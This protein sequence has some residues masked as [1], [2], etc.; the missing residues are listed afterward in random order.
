VDQAG[1]WIE[2]T[3]GPAAI[4]LPGEPA[5]L[6]PAGILWHVYDT[7]A[8]A[9]SA[10]L[11]DA[12]NETWIGWNLNSQRLSH[13]LT[14]GGGIPDFEY[15]IAGNPVGV[16][17][18]SAENA[19]LGVASVQ[20]TS[21]VTLYGFNKIGGA[22]PIWTLP[23][24]DGYNTVQFTS[25]DVAADGSIVVV[26]ASNGGN[27]DSRILLIDGATGLE[28]RHLQRPVNVIG[29]ELCDDGSRMILSENAVARVFD[30]ATLGELFNFSVSGGGGYHRI[31]RNGKVV[32]AGGFD[33][34]AYRDTGSGWVSAYSFSEASNW[35]GY[36]VAVSG[37]GKTLFDV[38]HNYNGYLKLTYRV[39][40]L[41]SGTELAKI[42]TQGAGTFQ[43][44]VARAQIS[45]DGSVMASA[46]WGSQDN[47]HPEVQVFDR[48]L[49]VIGSIDTPGSPFD[50]DLSRDGRYVAVGCKHVHA[51]TYGNGGDAYAFL[52]AT[53]YPKGDMNCD[54]VLDGGDIDPFFLALQ[55]PQLWQQQNPG[56]PLSNGDI[57]GDGAV[58]GGDIDPFFALLQG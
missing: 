21:G 30:T 25:L 48:T 18:A 50:L 6:D 57:N 13:L 38:A 44:S 45:Y 56:C 16:V 37:D 7:V 22:T 15:S 17:V 8:I 32:A 3:T 52:V 11:A 28:L 58:D 54:G 35:F 5:K 39:I 40:D 46:S 14:T 55:D 47:A 34:R 53:P 29:A 43:D 27:P 33:L 2:T 51:N 19:S 24:K 9:Q 4:V 49:K 20:L 12:T 10:C 36:G 31:S 23:L 1:A 26:A 41:V 42:T